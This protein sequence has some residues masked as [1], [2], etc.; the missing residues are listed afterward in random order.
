MVEAALFYMVVESSGLSFP[1]G[2]TLLR[3]HQLRQ[4]VHTVTRFSVLL[5]TRFA[6]GA[7]PHIVK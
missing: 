5:T 7:A 2:S 6:N 1:V 3:D 4:F